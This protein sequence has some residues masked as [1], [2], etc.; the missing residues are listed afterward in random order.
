MLS[1]DGIERFPRLKDGEILRFPRLRKHYHSENGTGSKMRKLR[2]RLASGILPRGW[3]HLSK[4]QKKLAKRVAS[5]MSVR[6]ACSLS[7]VKDPNTFYIWRE[8]HPLFKAYYYKVATRFATTINER[9]DSKLPRAV[10]VVEESLDNG[11]PYFRH[12]AAVQ[13]LKGRGVY[14]PTTNVQGEVLQK[15][16][17]SGSVDVKQTHKLDRE[18]AEMFVNALRNKAQGEGL[19]KIE[20]KIIDV[21]VVRELPPAQGADPLGEVQNSRQAEALEKD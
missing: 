14:K 4:D 1:Q 8:L 11:D 20:P 18:F 3:D 7:N 2:A 12:E 21:D 5:G 10:R 9:L 17:F 15:H 19:K 13:M 16:A 6:D